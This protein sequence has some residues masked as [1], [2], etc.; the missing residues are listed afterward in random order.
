MGEMSLVLGKPRSAT[1]VVGSAT[2][3][4]AEI[5]KGAL[6]ML[7]K[8]RPFLQASLPLSISLLL[9]LCAYVIALSL[10]HFPA[11][12][13]APYGRI[14]SLFVSI[15]RCLLTRPKTLPSILQRELEEQVKQRDE[16]NGEQ[17]KATTKR[18]R[19]GEP[20]PPSSDTGPAGKRR[21]QDKELASR[22]QR[23]GRLERK[24]RNMA[25]ATPEKRALVWVR[26]TLRPT[27]REQV[28]RMDPTIQHLLEAVHDLMLEL[29]DKEA[30]GGPLVAEKADQVKVMAAEARAA[31][32]TVRRVLDTESGSSAALMCVQWRVARRELRRGASSLI[33]HYDTLLMLLR[34]I[35]KIMKE[36]SKSSRRHARRATAFM[37]PLLLMENPAVTPA[38]LEV[39]SVQHSPR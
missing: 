2:C 23:K 9:S 26:E 8:T 38:T 5:T 34:A 31:L 27:V 14:V 32:L 20:S 39:G 16:Y 13:R 1:C 7:L 17:L 4:L 12:Q 37:G 29:V 6:Q 3:I 35:R 28:Q 24:I 30:M 11:K 10:R 19:N 25:Q 21:E 33:R 22:A 15:V 36:V 18:A